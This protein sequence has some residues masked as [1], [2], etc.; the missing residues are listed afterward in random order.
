M[1]VQW[2][3]QPPTISH[4]D[5]ETG[6]LYPAN[7]QASFRGGEVSFDYKTDEHG[8][9]NPSPWPSQAE[10][11]ITGD[12]EVF[13]Y[14]VDD[15]LAWTSIVARELPRSRVINLGLPG[16]APGQYLRVYRKFGVPLHPKLLVFGL[17]PGN[18]L[19]DEREFDAWLAA[20][21][22]GNY[23]TWRFVR[24]R[25][26]NR[27]ISLLSHTYMYWF[28][29]ATTQHLGAG[30][31]DKPMKFPDGSQLHFAAYFQQ[32][33]A[34]MAKADNP[35]F[36]SVLQSIE[37]AR[38]LAAQNGTELLVLLLPTKEDVYFPLRGDTAPPVLPPFASELEKRGIPHLDLTAPMQEEARKH[39]RLF[40]EVDGH[41]NAAG[42]RIIAN[43]VL[44]NL[45]QNAGKY[46]LT[47][48]E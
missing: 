6:F 33:E 23:D 1:R 16:M 12:S 17:F 20:G 45:H 22:P 10:V 4:G 19:S 48:W 41:P 11:V 24:G 15:S 35:S 7:H 42:Y 47:D 8:F 13:G 32:G 18:D 29:R 28:L 26:P 36:Q 37:E 9:R 3:S 40:F 39:Q 30:D 31:T 27:L 43:A 14:G 2:M 21:S 38:A 46:H 5:P 44:A 25:R 34:A